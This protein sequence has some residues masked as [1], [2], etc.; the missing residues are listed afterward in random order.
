VVI[1]K[2]GEGLGPSLYDRQSLPAPRIYLLM[3]RRA[4]PIVL[5]NGLA[6]Y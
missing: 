6:V 3:A 4:A 1:R 5:L 2:N